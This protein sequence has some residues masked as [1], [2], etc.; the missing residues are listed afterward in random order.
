MLE[1]NESGSDDLVPSELFPEGFF[2]AKDPNNPLGLF[3]PEKEM[4]LG[5]REPKIGLAN[6]FI[7]GEH[8]VSINSSTD[9]QGLL[10][11]LQKHESIQKPHILPCN[12][13]E[14]IRFRLGQ[15]AQQIGIL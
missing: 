4:E 3:D 9:P 12:L 5:I 1:D 13:V 6:Q 2:G 7:M 8:V 15:W 14:C 11:L 10:Y